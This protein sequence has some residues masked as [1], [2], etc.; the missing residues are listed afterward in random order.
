MDGLCKHVEHTCA[1]QIK[2]GMRSA[3]RDCP[4]ISAKNQVRTIGAKSTRVSPG[5]C[6]FTDIDSTW[7]LE[8]SQELI[9]T[10]HCNLHKMSV[11]C[12]KNAPFPSRKRMHPATHI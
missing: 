11:M 6:V 4:G 12:C 10:P 2:V 5:V 7:T 9:A 1:D 8:E 3:W